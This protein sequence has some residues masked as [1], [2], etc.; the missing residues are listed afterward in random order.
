VVDQSSKYR[1]IIKTTS[2]FGGVQI[3]TII[4]SI[5]RSKFIAILLGPL[6]MGIAGLLTSTIS[7]VGSLTEFG[8]GTSA[9]KNISIANA[10]NDA[11]RMAIVAS[12]LRRLVWLTG[13]LGTLVTL[14]L[15]PW[16]SRLTFGNEDY[17]Y[18]FVWLS[19]TLLFSQLTSGQLV[20]LQ[21]MR[22]LQYLA[23][24]NISGSIIG[25]IISIPIYFLFRINGIVPAILISSILSL[26][27]SVI[28]SSKINI[29]KISVTR[30]MIMTEGSDMMKMGF[31]LSLSGLMSLGASYILRIYI[32]HQGGIARVGLYSAGFAIINTYVGLVF[33]AMGTDYYPRLSELANDNL[34]SNQAIN[35]QAEIAV[36]I[37]APIL[38]V[39]LV[40][41][42]WIVILLYSNKFVEVTEMIHWA[43]LGMFFKAASWSVGFI[44][45]AKGATKI[46]FY[47]EL[48]ANAYMLTFNIIMYK[49]FELKGLGISFLMG[50]FILLIQVYI[51][52]KRKYKF[53]F[54]K[55][56]IKIFIVQLSVA[57]LCFVTVEKVQNPY[58]FILGTILIVISTYFSLVEL[59]K[60]IGLKYA[61]EEF[62]R[63]FIK[64]Q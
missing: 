43:A 37:L 35:Q 26:T 11:N 12:V 64:K 45:L 42:S 38:S 60:R 57:I 31:L 6:G 58:N 39:F 25:L 10:S 44:L 52:S 56:F 27:L 4:V 48:I 47:S 13:L 2:I 23:K 21:G 3:L 15:A 30:R 50:Y 20:L 61:L 9:V 16:L 54:D 62:K 41:I 32:S 29:C 22:K 63:R 53:N 40:F 36:L 7:I 14:I 8:L 34:K 19:I 49:Y 17:T 1:H 24:A 59:D 33:N 46:F 28:Y 51:I 55:G 18:A 5:V